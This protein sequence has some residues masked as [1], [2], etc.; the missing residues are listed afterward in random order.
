MKTNAV[1]TKKPSEIHFRFGRTGH[2]QMWLHE[3]TPYL[4][5]GRAVAVPITRNNQAIGIRQAARRLGLSIS[6]R[7]DED[8]QFW[9]LP[10]TKRQ[11]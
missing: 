2:W 8:G 5:D 7:E 10:K 4:K 9:V 3:I 1:V 11:P 6:V